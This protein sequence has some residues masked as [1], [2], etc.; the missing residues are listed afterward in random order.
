[1]Q[2]ETDK[3]KEETLDQLR[4]TPAAEP[5]TQLGSSSPLVTR[6]KSHE[7]EEGPGKEAERCSKLNKSRQ[8]HACMGSAWLKPSQLIS[9]CC[10]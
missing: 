2:A 1:M 10:L 8:Y 7:L 6:A 5:A 4:R 9:H 3:E